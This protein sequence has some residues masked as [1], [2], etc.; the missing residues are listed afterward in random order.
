MEQRLSWAVRA[1]AWHRDGSH[2]GGPPRLSG[3]G[4]ELLDYLGRIS[5]PSFCITL[6]ALSTSLSLCK[7]NNTSAGKIT[8]S[9]LSH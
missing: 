2:G 7:I 3:G 9:L 5:G 8:G 4:E 1:L 6:C